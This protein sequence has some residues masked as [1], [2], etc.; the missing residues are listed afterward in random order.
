MTP[1]VKKRPVF[2]ASFS[3]LDPVLD[4]VNVDYKG[5]ESTF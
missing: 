5:L 3:L 2:Y 4:D 1:Q